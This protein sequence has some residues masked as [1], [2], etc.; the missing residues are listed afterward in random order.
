MVIPVGPVGAIQTLWSFAVD[1]EGELLA[2]NLGGVS[3][4]P[5]TRAED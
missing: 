2:E 4:V 5:F 3:F 1:E